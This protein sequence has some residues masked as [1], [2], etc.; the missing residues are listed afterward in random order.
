MQRAAE[1]DALHG[2]SPVCSGEASM[3]QRGKFGC[4]SSEHVGIRR[5]W[6][7]RYVALRHAGH[8]FAFRLW[9]GTGSSCLAR[10]RSLVC[11][12]R[13]AECA[14]L[15]FRA[16]HPIPPPPP[17]T[18]FPIPPACTHHAS[19]ITPTV[20]TSASSSPCPSPAP[21][22]GP[23]PPPPPPPHRAPPH[24]RKPTRSPQRRPSRRPRATRG[25]SRY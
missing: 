25:S 17:P 16:A 12:A 18:A 7:G 1:S 2:C 23:P 19:T 20:S 24:R 14:S 10:S 11:H 22:P 21:T 6:I 13:H 5:G 9:Q 15:A 4:I 8:V 3:R